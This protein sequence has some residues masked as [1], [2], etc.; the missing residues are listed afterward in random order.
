MWLLA[1]IPVLA[2]GWLYFLIKWFSE[3]QFY[4]KRNW[5]YQ[6]DNPKG[7][8]I[9]KGEFPSSENLLSN[10]ERL[11]FGYPFFLFVI[12]AILLGFVFAAYE[13]QN[14][15]QKDLQECGIT[16]RGTELTIAF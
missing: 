6:D 12:G 15:E 13:I 16:F 3:L 8:R 1:C 14:C 4:K 5:N 7:L 2:G 10:K 11:V 9:H